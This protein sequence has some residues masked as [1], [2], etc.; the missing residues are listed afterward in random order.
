[1]TGVFFLLVFLECRNNSVDKLIKFAYISRSEDGKSYNDIYNEELIRKFSRYTNRNVEVIRGTYEELREIDDIDIFIDFPGRRKNVK[2]VEDAKKLVYI[3]YANTALPAKDYETGKRIALFR[4]D[5]IFFRNIAQ[6]YYT[7]EYHYVDSIEEGFGLLKDGSVDAFLSL[8]DPIY[9]RNPERKNISQINVQGNYSYDKTFYLLNT[10]VEG[11]VEKFLKVL[12]PKDKKDLEKNT[13]TK[14][15][16]SQINLNKEEA[17]YLKN[18]RLIRI[19]ADF[20]RGAPLAYYDNNRM[21]GSISEYMNLLR[22]GTGIQVEYVNKKSNAEILKGLRNN[23]VDLDATYTHGRSVY[24]IAETTPYFSS[25]IGV[26]SLADRVGEDV[27]KIFG[28]FD[29]GMG[30]TGVKLNGGRGNYELVQNLE[31]DS[32]YRLLKSGEIDYFTHSYSILKHPH[33]LQGIK[34]LRLF[35]VLD[36]KISFSMAASEENK[37]I[38]DIINRMFQYLDHDEIRYKWEMNASS[39]EKRNTYKKFVF[40]FGVALV[41]LLPYIMILKVEME[42]IKKI[43][44]ELQETK[45]NLENALNI[46]SAFL[47]NMSHEM[48]TPLTAILGFNKLLI[49]K[50]EDTKKRQLLGNI[51]VAGKTLLEFINNVLDLSKLESG[52]IELKYKRINLFQMADDLERISLGLKRSDDVEFCF[53]ITEDAPRYFMGDEVWLKEIILNLLG[54]AFKF[55]EKGSVQLLM[56]RKDENLIIEVKDTGIGM[57]NFE[58]EGEKIFKRYEQLDLNENRDKKGSGLGLAIV[59]E[60]VELMEGSIG[61]E[62]IYKQGTTFRIS[63]PIKKKLELHGATR[64]VK[65]QGGSNEREGL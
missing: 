22:A 47:A 56:R 30:A 6:R 54:N 17:Q 1:M 7:N 61:V 19:G 52:R 9:M 53:I 65:V 63:L 51:E 23:T 2:K 34:D 16:W 5:N 38:I 31:T 60:V 27:E 35:G 48:R 18:K 10:E 62:S 29:G 37:I 64:G 13:E 20:N 44:R 24:G 14:L 59:K 12:E 57:K 49:R 43:E 42:K 41:L 58:K 11:S 21:K 32:L 50:E 55:T 36:K 33:N 28:E 4:G 40:L 3:L 15:I 25:M 46:K 45:K 39:I 26:F 8:E